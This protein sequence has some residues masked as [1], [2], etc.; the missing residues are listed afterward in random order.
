MSI[1]FN[2][3]NNTQLIKSVIDTI[4][5]GDTANVSDFIG[6]TYYNHESQMDPVRSK[7]EGGQKNSLIL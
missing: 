7:N 4:N 2:D 3:N 6:P 5:T 1:K